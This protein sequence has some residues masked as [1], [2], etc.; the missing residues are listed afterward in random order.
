M[1]PPLG[2]P[3]PPFWLAG[4]N[5]TAV[6][7]EDL[8]GRPAL[9]LFVPSAFTPVCTS[10]IRSHGNAELSPSRLVVI[11]CDSAHTL[12]RWLAQEG[13][14]V[15]HDVWVGSD[16]WPH[17]AVS[18]LF[19]AFD[20]VHGW[21]RRVTVLLDGDGCV[22]WTTSSPGGVARDPADAVAAIAQLPG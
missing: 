12:V 21:P 8:R 19:G 22:R 5:G 16:F 1:Q 2:Q 7:G 18:Q 4:P 6:T 9:L 3:A 13:I 14:A 17:G 10:E 11:S 20:E 15:G